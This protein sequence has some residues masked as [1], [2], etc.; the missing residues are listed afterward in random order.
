MKI[1]FPKG[2][3]LKLQDFG[4]RIAKLQHEPHKNRIRTRMHLN[5]V[6]HR[7]ILFCSMSFTEFIYWERRVWQ[8]PFGHLFSCP[9][10]W[11]RMNDSIPLS[12]ALPEYFSSWILTLQNISGICLQNKTKH[13]LQTQGLFFLFFFFPLD[14]PLRCCGDRAHPTPVMLVGLFWGVGRILQY[15]TQ[16][17]SLGFLTET[18]LSSPT[19]AVGQW[20]L[21][22]DP[23]QS[24]CATLPTAHP[25]P[26]LRKHTLRRTFS[27]ANHQK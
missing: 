7:Q 11:Q 3:K 14:I 9:T 12:T 10:A 16:K 1:M 5:E 6:N 15:Y 27:G 2:W 19:A 24:L 23:W 21:R 17:K 18:W 13:K 8:Q 4:R 22:W 20:K 26:H 25:T